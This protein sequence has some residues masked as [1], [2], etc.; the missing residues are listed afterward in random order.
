MTIMIKDVTRVLLFSSCSHA[1]KTFMCSLL[2][3]HPNI[4]GVNPSSFTKN[5]M[6]VVTKAQ[7][8]SSSDMQSYI[9]NC[10]EEQFR[11]DV[12]N[13]S[14]IGRNENYWTEWLFNYKC[15]L[16]E[17]LGD[18]KSFT[19]KEILLAIYWAFYYVNKVEYDSAIEPI[20]FL[21]LHDDQDKSD[22]F[23]QWLDDIGFEITLL[24][25]IRTPF[26]KLGSYI[27]FMQDRDICSENILRHLFY[28]SREVYTEIELKYPIL[29]YRFEDLKLYPKTILN[30]ICEKFGIPWNDS[31]LEASFLGKDVVYTSHGEKTE[32][33]AKKQVWYTYEEYFDSFDRLRLEIL[34][35]RIN[36]AYMYSHTEYYKYPV[37]NEELV[38]WFNIPF[39]FE[40]YICFKNAKDKSDFR[41]RLKDMA[42]RAI[43]GYPNEN[44][45]DFGEFIKVK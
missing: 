33:F 9:L 19:E 20:L 17:I 12:W 5:I 43:A 18:K 13:N 39:K 14:F 45:F 44:G 24:R 22:S 3:G 10:L 36:Q 34:F 37:H 6:S 26:I 31:L 23:I 35:N 28:L 8:M 42:R 15:V 32:T 27:K 16:H 7:K 30:G 40:K 21:D 38:E 4:L 29:R 1:G 25:A 11:D 2:D 41:L